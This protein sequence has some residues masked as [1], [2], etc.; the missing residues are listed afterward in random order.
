MEF[1]ESFTE[2]TFVRVSHGNYPLPLC[3]PR[4]A[5]LRRR[6]AHSRARCARFR[7]ESVFRRVL[8]GKHGEGLDGRGQKAGCKSE[9]QA[10]QEL[11]E[12]TPAKKCGLI[13][14]VGISSISK[15]HRLP[16]AR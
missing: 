13:T 7:Y 5:A 10:N 16:F 3:L 1:A 12:F 9:V 14:S 8:K 4:S 11:L 15:L 2:L 6:S